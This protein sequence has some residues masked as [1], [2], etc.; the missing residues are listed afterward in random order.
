MKKMSLLV[1]NAKESLKKA[2]LDALNTA[3]S[4]GLLPQAELPACVL[5]VPADRAHGD[6]SCN[7]ALAGAKVFRAAPQK[8]A[9]AVKEK[10]DLSQS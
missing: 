4:A 5:E 10:N 1:A 8:I 9:Q 3:I 2:I 7:I 6:W